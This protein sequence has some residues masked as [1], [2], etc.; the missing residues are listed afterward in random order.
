MRMMWMPALLALVA[1]A[2]DTADAPSKETT[3]GR[4]QILEKAAEKVRDIPPTVGE[5]MAS[6]PEDVWVEPD[7]ENVIYM[8]VPAGR[9]VIALTSDLAP[10]HT[11]QMKTLVREG[12][13][14]GLDFY[15]VVHG[16]VAQ[17]GDEDA[18]KDIGSAKPQLGAEF[19][20]PFP[21][22]LSWTTHPYVDGYADEEV[23]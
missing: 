19:E 6:A 17:G 7:P 5:V 3:A 15:R 2:P 1:C 9:I 14:D 16:F 10:N 23:V 12:Y 22:G 11:A 21:E 4:A 13:Y 8:D 18:E 20:E